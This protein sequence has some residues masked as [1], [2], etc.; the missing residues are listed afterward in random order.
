MK[1]IA[2]RFPTLQRLSGLLFLLIAGVALNVVP[3]GETVAARDD[4]EFTVD[5]DDALFGEDVFKSLALDGITL[6]EGLPDQTNASQQKS[7]NAPLANAALPPR[8]DN[9]QSKYF[10]PI[11]QQKG[12]SC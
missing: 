11:M 12:G 6:I 8:V 9:T 5:E 3:S 7:A 2:R 4:Q 1:K 10:P